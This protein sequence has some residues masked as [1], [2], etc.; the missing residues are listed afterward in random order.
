MSAHKYGLKWLTV[1]ELATLGVEEKIAQCP[2][3]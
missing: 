3:L 1:E 2:Y